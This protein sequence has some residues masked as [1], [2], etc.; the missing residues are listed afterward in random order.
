MKKLL[1]IGVDFDGTVVTHDYPEIGRDIGAIPI[2]K[3]LIE[4]GHKIILN[5]MRSGQQLTEAI[6]WF[7]QNEIDLFGVQENPTQKEWTTSSKVYAHIY[8][9]DAALG[10]PLIYDKHEK[11][12]IDWNV[13]AEYFQL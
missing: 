12:Y 4:Q 10:A 11:P 6:D 2:L 5:T 9:D 1:F 3:K 7:E 13:V 8:I